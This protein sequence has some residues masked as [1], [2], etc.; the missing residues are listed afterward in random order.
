MKPGWVYI[1]KCSDGSYYTGSTTEI[2]RRI[3]EHQ[4]GEGAEWTKRRLP[5]EVVYM[6]EL[7]DEN[8]AYIAEQK[9]KKWS[10]AKKEALI[11]GNWNLL[12]YLAKKPVF[13]EGKR[14]D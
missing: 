8:T 5:V 4:I 14:C 10:R 3:Q 2:N 7:L 9:V 13:R 11:A 6:Q 1:L 12:H